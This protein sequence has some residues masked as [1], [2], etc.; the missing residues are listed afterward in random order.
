M[1]EE[2]N[3][4]LIVDDEEPIRRLLVSAL[5]EEGFDARGAATG[6][7]ALAEL[8]RDDGW[9][10]LLTDLRMPGLSGEELI[11]AARETRPDL[12]VVIISG[13]LGADAARLA[14]RTGV[15]D[16]IEKPFAD[17]SEIAVRIREALDRRRERRA[18]E[19]EVATLREKSRDQE[20]EIAAL[21]RTVDVTRRNLREQLRTIQKSREIFYTDLSRV[22]AIVDNLIDGIV[23]TDLGGQVILIN[24]TA[25]KMLGIPSFT[26]LGKPLSEVEGNRGLLSL[27]ATHRAL[28]LDELGAQAEATTA[29]DGTE[30][31]FSVHTSLIRDFQ[32]KLSGVLSLIRDISLRKKTEQ[33]KN[34]FL[35]IVAHELRTPLTAIKAFATILT[36]GVYGELQETQ[37]SMVSD[38][39]SQSD[40]LGHEID[41]IISLGRLESSDFAPDLDESSASDILKRLV[42]PFENE[43]KEKGIDLAVEDVT[44]GAM[45][46]ANAR[47]IRRAVRALVEN[48]LKFTPEGGS[49]AL[50]ISAEP[51]HVL[52]EVEDTGIGIA[53]QDHEVIFETF[54]Q[55]ENP[56]TRKYGGSG[57][58]LTFVAEIL[59]AHGTKVDLESEL[60]EGATF[61]F[62][63]PRVQ[64]E[65]DGELATA[66]GPQSEEDARVVR[67]SS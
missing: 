39:L 46:S 15:A 13:H 52:F 22:M 9:D 3:R 11:L 65:A 7:D 40:R 18:G 16:M 55:L 8:S 53:P 21:E 37:M 43:A 17:L 35:S 24:P 33:M 41:K 28:E 66:G 30:S 54:N 47:D 60:G 44:D 32:G 6:D 27:L 38:I 56:L 19:A 23:F 57:L 63:L 2:R 10:L 34:Q 1:N 49:V 62:R 5:T 25:G 48:A 67:P 45:V 12:D 64:E 61:R 4:I 29:I 36:K 58:G 14:L 20:K 51:D 26:A 42:V 50:R 31:H 59:K